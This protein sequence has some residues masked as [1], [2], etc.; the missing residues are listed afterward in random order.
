MKKN[1]RFFVRHVVLLLFVIFY[2]FQL[3]SANRYWVGGSGSW[4]DNSHWSATNGGAGGASLPSSADDV[5]FTTSSGFGVT[6]AL[7]TITMASGPAAV[8]RN[9]TFATGVAPIMVGTGLPHKRLDVYGSYTLE[10]GMYLLG[11]QGAIHFYGAAGGTITTAGV[12][13]YN[14]TIQFENTCG[15]YVV[16]GDW[17][18]RAASSY[19]F[20]V[21]FASNATTLTFNG[22]FYTGGTMNIN[23]GTVNLNAGF[24]INPTNATS[25]ANWNNDAILHSYGPG[26]CAFFYQRGE[27][28]F[29]GQYY[30][31]AA[32]GEIPATPLVFGAPRVFDIE[33]CTIDITDYWR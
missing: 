10:T 1:C 5:F 22:V 25:A 18:R 30:E 32:L 13:H 16:N 2:S 31:I 19:S 7:K 15:N 6:A 17:H 24:Q 21:N 11:W 27:T 12:N 4:Q 26:A 28:Y 9:I 3:F 14:S 23:K 8:V 33:N 29:H 20:N